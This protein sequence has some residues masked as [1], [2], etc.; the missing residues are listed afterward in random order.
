MC[1]LDIYGGVCPVEHFLGVL[2]MKRTDA[3]SI[4][5]RAVD[6][7]DRKGKQLGLFSFYLHYQITLQKRSVLKD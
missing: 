7:L 6:F 2:N 5:S 3:A 1:T 4:T